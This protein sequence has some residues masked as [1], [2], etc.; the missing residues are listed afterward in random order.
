[1]P[2]PWRRH[3]RHKR[4]AYAATSSGIKSREVPLA[5]S[6]VVVGAY[7]GV[8]EALCRR[9]ATRG[10]RVLMSGRDPGRLDRL[11]ADIGG[12]TVAKAGVEG[13]AL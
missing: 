10:A 12:E 2:Q 6:F 7:G 11:A 4:V 13:L 9:L 8:G 3:E 5:Q 1:M